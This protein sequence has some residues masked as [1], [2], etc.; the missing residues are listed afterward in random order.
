M[1][2]TPSTWSDA[3]P[4]GRTATQYLAPQSNVAPEETADPT[5]AMVDHAAAQEEAGRTLEQVIQ[6]LLQGNGLTPLLDLPVQDVLK[7]LNLPPLPQLPPAP[8]PSQQTS[9]APLDIAGLIKPVLDMAAAFGTGKL[10]GGSGKGGSGNGGGSDPTQGLSAISSALQTATQMGTSALQA[11]MALWQGLGANAAA[12][13]SS[14]VQQNS[15]AADTQG[16]QVK[17]LV[18]DGARVV[19]QGV[20]ELG[21]IVT[22]FFSAITAAGPFL[23]TPPGQAWAVGLA[24]ESAAEASGV[25][26]KTKAELTEKSG[27][28]TATGEKVPIT[29]PPGGIDPLMQ[30]SQILGVVTPLMGLAATGVQALSGLAGGLSTGTQAATGA[31]DKGVDAVGKLVDAGAQAASQL[32]AANPALSGYPAGTLPPGS[33]GKSD[34]DRSGASTKVTPTAFGGVPSSAGALNNWSGSSTKLGPYGSPLT[35]LTPTVDG[36]ATAAARSGTPGVPAGGMPLGGAAA[37]GAG[38]AG[39][40]GKHNTDNTGVATAQYGDELVGL[41][42][43]ASLPVIGADEEDFEAPDTNL[44]V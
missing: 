11:A 22:R 17:A 30:A 34:T 40:G 13:K 2:Q 7:A 9:S 15:T 41:M 3:E 42:A 31:I 6:D 26:A 43:G 16:Q 24:T 5:G 19:G 20:T 23:W 1:P 32:A 25:V 14:E 28:M 35:P 38:R 10:G 44:I 36:T 18:A 39:D 27:E 37:P 21:G 8:P 12:T 4:Q 33:D 29:T